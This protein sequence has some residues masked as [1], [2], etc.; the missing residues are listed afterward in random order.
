MVNTLFSIALSAALA[1]LAIKVLIV[2]EVVDDT[3][4]GWYLHEASTLPSG[5][6]DGGMDEG[7]DR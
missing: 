7:G 5:T 6:R 3:P 1:A 2:V 4:L